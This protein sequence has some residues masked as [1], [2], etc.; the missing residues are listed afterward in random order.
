LPLN[1]AAIMHADLSL[2]TGPCLSEIS[3]VDLVVIECRS[4]VVPLRKFKRLRE[5]GGV[6]SVCVCLNR[7]K[8]RRV[9][10]PPE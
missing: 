1:T 8:A 2:E 9:T 4:L 7:R 3:I 5:L 10:E 6:E